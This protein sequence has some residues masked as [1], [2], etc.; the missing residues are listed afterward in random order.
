MKQQSIHPLILL[1]G[2]L[3]YLICLLFIKNIPSLI[4][5]LTI[6]LL[7]ITYIRIPLKP[8]FQGVSRLWLFLI[9]TFLFHLILSGHNSAINSQNIIDNINIEGFSR[10]VFY[11]IRLALIVTVAVS[12]FLI[13]PPQ[14]YGQEMGRFLSRLPFGRSTFAQIEL[15]I[16][17]ALRFIPFLEEEIKRLRLTLKA[18]GLNGRKGLLG[19]LGIWRKMIYPL[20]INAFRRSDMVAAALQARGF[21]PRIRRTYYIDRKVP[22]SQWIGLGF[23]SMACLISPG[24]KFFADI[25]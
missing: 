8:I 4:L 25:F 20:I 21:D 3:C 19:S 2:A 5:L 24:I 23:F 10:A 18:R 17:L 16:T 11:T 12:L 1:F 9:L 15:L 7:I 13:Y 6:G 22:V 14:R